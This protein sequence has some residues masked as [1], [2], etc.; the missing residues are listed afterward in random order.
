MPLDPHVSPRAR[1]D[2]RRWKLWVEAELKR[3]RSSAGYLKHGTIPGSVTTIREI[4]L[5]PTG[6]AGYEDQ[7]T[8]T[9]VADDTA[10]TLT[11]SH[12]PI[13]KSVNIYKDGV[14]LHPWEFTRDGMVVT[15]PPSADVIIRAGNVFDAWYVWD[16]TYVAP[17]VPPPPIPEITLVGT[18]SQV[19]SG[20]IALPAGTQAGD[21]IVVA[22]VGFSG[23]SYSDSRLVANSINGAG[24][25]VAWGYE[26]GS[27]NPVGVNPSGFYISTSVAVYRGVVVS[28][29]DITQVAATP[30]VLPTEVDAYAAIGV[31]TGANGIIAGLLAGD[32]TL[33]WQHNVAQDGTKA[34]TAIH[35]W[36]S[37]TPVATPAGSFNFTG[38]ITGATQTTLLLEAA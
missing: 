37:A 22:S 38:D 6:A 9:A 25:V 12:T 20:S 8:V 3:L 1:D 2:L 5:D 23:N 4:L 21:L 17:P 15:I 16:T 14:R 18:N 29:F 26:D 13:Y 7:D 19:S 30:M 36:D 35:S 10:V 32:S 28:D 11:L 33:A 27:G 31:I 24:V 34:H